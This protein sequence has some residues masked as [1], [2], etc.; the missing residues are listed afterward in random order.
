MI[1][2]V[3]T[4]IVNVANLVEAEGKAAKFHAVKVIK[5]F[6]AY[7]AA[8]MVGTV[9]LI[10]FVGGVFM[11]LD[12]VMPRFAAL[13]VVGGVMIVIAAGLLAVARKEAS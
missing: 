12:A 4:L 2:A 5:L 13:L 8:T 6:Y 10:V 3:S 11:A 9:G 7:A 1:E